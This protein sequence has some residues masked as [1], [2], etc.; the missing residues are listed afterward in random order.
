MSATSGASLAGSRCNSIPSMVSLG[1]I[2]RKAAPSTAAQVCGAGMA[3]GAAALAA[4]TS[5][6]SP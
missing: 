5:M 6:T 4:A 3:R 1:V 2:C